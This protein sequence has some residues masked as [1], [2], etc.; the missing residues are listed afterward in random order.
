L[1]RERPEGR[2]EDL[3]G[4]VQCKNLIQLNLLDLADRQKYQEMRV[5][6]RCSRFVAKSVESARRLLKE[7]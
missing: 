6:N 4:T 2:Q 3:V 7:K 5:I 1:E